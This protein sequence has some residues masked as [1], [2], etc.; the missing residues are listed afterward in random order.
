[1]SYYRH[2]ENTSA[3][4]MIGYT[5]V[6]PFL[7]FVSVVCKAFIKNKRFD[8]DVIFIFFFTF[9]VIWFITLFFGLILASIFSND[10][11]PESFFYFLAHVIVLMV[12]LSFILYSFINSWLHERSYGNVEYN[13]EFVVHSDSGPYHSD[14]S[15]LKKAFQK[16][17]NTFE[18][19]N[20]FRLAANYTRKVPDTILYKQDS[21]LL[22]Y[23]KY[24]FGRQLLFSKV[25]AYKDSI[26][27]YKKDIPVKGNAEIHVLDEE[28]DEQLKE[29]REIIDSVNIIIEKKQ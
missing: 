6:I 25:L 18:D 7:A 22:F 1:M 21:V 2:F 28:F 11:R 29:F 5:S 10:K 13:H 15:R 27:L 20:S 3:F 16:L 24:Q 9:F 19:S 8:F 14:T 12:I 4:K 23:F 26:F 17:E